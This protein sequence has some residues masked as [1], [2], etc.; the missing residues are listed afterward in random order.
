MVSMANRKLE[1][2]HFC[3]RVERYCARMNGGLSAVALLLAAAT[4]WLGALRLS[5]EIIRDVQSDNLPFIEMSTDEPAMG[6]GN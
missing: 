3:A 1:L 5:E 2:T 4:L 6:I